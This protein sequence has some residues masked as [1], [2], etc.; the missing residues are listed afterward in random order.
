LS[1]TPGRYEFERTI[2]GNF[3]VSAEVRKLSQEE[4]K[5]KKVKGKSVD[6]LSPEFSRKLFP[7]DFYL[8]TFTFCLCK[9]AR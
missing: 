7:P 9:I 2:N 4:G 8:F 3:F 1:R 6:W 5:S